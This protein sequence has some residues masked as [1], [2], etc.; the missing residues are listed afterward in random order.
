M[1]VYNFDKDDRTT[2]F[3]HFVTA[4]AD[5]ADVALIKEGHF[6]VAMVEEDSNVGSDGAHTL[7]PMIVDQQV[8]LLPCLSSA[9]FHGSCAPRLAS[10]PRLVSPRVQ[11]VFGTD[12]T[13]T[14]PRR[15]FSSASR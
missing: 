4:P 2:P 13:L 5:T 6:A 12:T 3:F 14:V 11:M 1:H 9:C 8:R 7:L 15:F 10:T